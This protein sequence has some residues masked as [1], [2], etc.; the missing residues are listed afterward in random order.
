MP[1][2]HLFFLHFQ[3]FSFIYNL[4]TY[5]DEFR[6]SIFTF[7]IH[8]FFNH[9]KD[10]SPAFF[11]IFSFMCFFFV[12]V[13]WCSIFQDIFFLSS[14]G[15]VLYE[16]FSRINLLFFSFFPR[17]FWRFLSFF[18]FFFIFFWRVLASIMR[19]II[20]ENLKKKKSSHDGDDIMLPV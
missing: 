8:H 16:Y 7:I 4:K 5:L 20:V 12:S 17:I 2:I 6:C 3:S 14:Q 18:Y 15:W 11:C 19:R 9:L 1:W 10:V 13:M